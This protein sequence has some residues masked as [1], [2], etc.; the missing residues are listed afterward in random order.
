M[1]S[2]NSLVRIKDLYDIPKNLPGEDN[3]IPNVQLIQ[4]ETESKINTN[5]VNE[6]SSKTNLLNNA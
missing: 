3:E 4:S 5:L 1:K 2:F 6:N